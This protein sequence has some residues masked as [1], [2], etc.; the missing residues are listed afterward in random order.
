MHLHANFQFFILRGIYN[1]VHASIYGTQGE[2]TEPGNRSKNG[3]NRTEIAKIGVKS[4]IISEPWRPFCP[5]C[6][7]IIVKSDSA[8]KW[9]AMGLK[10]DQIT[11][12]IV[13]IQLFLFPQCTLPASR[14]V[15]IFLFFKKLTCICA[16]NFW[17]QWGLSWPLKVEQLSVNEARLGIFW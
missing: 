7:N 1:W 11:T 15:S 5:Y 4:P 16:T 13:D 3:Q 17:I 12:K 10:N 2:S 14:L 9:P 6:Y 8:S